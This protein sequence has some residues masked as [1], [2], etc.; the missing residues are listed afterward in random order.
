MSAA[1]YRAAHRAF[2]E[3][4][5]TSVLCQEQVLSGGREADVTA[6]HEA[7]AALRRQNPSERP[8]RSGS[9]DQACPFLSGM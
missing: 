6:I 1:V 5:R 4:R 2:A 9:L 7:P 8:M 3:V